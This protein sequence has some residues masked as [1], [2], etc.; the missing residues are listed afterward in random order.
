MLT[1]TVVVLVFWAFSSGAAV[2]NGEIALH[3]QASKED[4]QAEA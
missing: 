4:P 3:G 1:S 2:E